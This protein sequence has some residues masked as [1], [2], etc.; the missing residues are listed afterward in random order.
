MTHP[1]KVTV[2]A[3]PNGSGKST[4]SQLLLQTELPN[5][6]NPDF[7]AKS[8]S[9]ENP[10]SASFAAGRE[11]HKII[12]NYVKVHSDFSFETTLSGKTYIRLLSQLKQKGYEIQLIYV[13]L[14]TPDL[15]V[16]RVRERVAAGGHSIPE[17]QIRKRY[18]TSL[19]N[20]FHDY[21]YVC[22][23]WFMYDNSVY[24]SPQIIAGYI[25]GKLSIAQPLVWNR[26]V[27][28]YGGK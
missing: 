21:K 20:F 22:D 17:D 2:L 15:A 26:L 4:A 10:A 28:D 3:G 12:R 18:H 25:G 7:V 9:P 23:K 24:E 11:V 8:I 6:I 5:F 14:S 1:P 19:V 13:W 16:L 27:S